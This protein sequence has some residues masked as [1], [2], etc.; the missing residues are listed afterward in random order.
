MN[1]RKVLTES[2]KGFSPNSTALDIHLY[3]DDSG[4]RYSDRPQTLRNDGMDYFAL[5]GVLINDEDIGHV[6]H[7]HS[8]L[9]SKWGLV[10]P[11]HSTKIRG[12]RG[13]FSWLSKDVQK[14]NEFM[15][16]L[17]Y[18]VLNSPILSIS[19]VIDRPGYVNRY[20]EKHPNPWL[21]CQTAFAILIERAAKYA[22]RQN[23]RL[24]VFF[25]GSGKV[26]DRS[27]LR[28]M[29]SL[30]SDGMPFPGAS[31]AGY[32]SLTSDEFR[33]IV[34]G[35]PSRVTKSVPMVQLADLVLYAMARGGY[36]EEYPPY[37]ALHRHSKIID[38]ALTPNEIPSRGVKYSCFDTKKA[39]ANPSL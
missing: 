14:A 9:F 2:E 34:R 8:Q 37:R 19:C 31:A 30:K 38:A 36:D 3:I 13:S 24:S 35:E 4:S 20:S 26:E 33:Q 18:F 21:L 7:A 27:I 10:E 15:K 29:R 28:Y 32:E 6:L 17:N 16:D 39:R 25:E 1:M 11:L 12:F 5:G 23:R 22:Q